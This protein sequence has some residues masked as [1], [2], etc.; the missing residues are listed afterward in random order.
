M[1]RLA[2]ARRMATIQFS[3]IAL[4]FQHGAVTVRTHLNQGQFP[5]YHTLIPTSLPHKVSFDAEEA[6]RAVRSLQ[7]I[8]E[9]GSGILR[10]TWSD[11]ALTISAIGEELG[12]IAVSVRAHIQGGEGKIA[13]DVKYLTP[14]L[15]GKVGMVLMETSTVSSPARFFHIGSPDVVL[16]P[17]FVQWGDEAL[18]RADTPTPIEEAPPET[19]DNEEPAPESPPAAAKPRARAKRSRS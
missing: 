6:G 12:A 4:S 11:D 7:G 3:N 16:M 15:A 9:D 5:N 17:M 19:V 2:V 10:L 14:Y 13:F 1:A 8:A 18:D